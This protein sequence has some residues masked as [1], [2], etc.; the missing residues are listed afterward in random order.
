M[1]LMAL[2]L[3]QRRYTQAQCRGRP[4]RTLTHNFAVDPSA[5]LGTAG[6]TQCQLK[7]TTI[8]ESQSMNMC[9]GV[10]DV[11]GGEAPVLQ[12]FALE[13]KDNPV[14]GGSGATWGGYGAPAPK[15]ALPPAT[16]SESAMAMRRLFQDVS[17]GGP[18][19]AIP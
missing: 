6:P 8:L 10:E 19:D 12:D 4:H 3:L 13:A 5:S 17:M 2:L 16:A 9:K 14:G 18:V 1:V 7:A 11:L 15:A